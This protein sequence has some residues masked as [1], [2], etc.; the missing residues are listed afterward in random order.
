LGDT[1]VIDIS[2][3]SL[4]RVWSRLRGWVEEEAQ[5]ARIY[6]RLHETAGL[7]AEN[8][9]GLYHDPDLQIAR[10]WREASGPNSAWAGQY[11]GGFDEAMAFLDTSREAA[12]HEE[13]E[14]EAA[15]QHELERARQLAETQAKVA[16]LFKRFAG[17]L[18]VG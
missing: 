7:H 18:A 17:G 15:R 2:D 6:H 1:T 11:G 10:S 8:R 16:R 13:K 9:A 4:M 12:E 3:E 5:S 14:R